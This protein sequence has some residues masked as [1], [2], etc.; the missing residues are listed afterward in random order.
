MP[1][2]APDFVHA[3]YI[4]ANVDKVWNGLW[5]GKLTRAYW[6]HDNVSDWKVGS[7]WEHVGASRGA[8]VVP[9]VALRQKQ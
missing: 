1:E 4:A 3:I 6:K 8:R 2:P 9:R 5:D 7:R